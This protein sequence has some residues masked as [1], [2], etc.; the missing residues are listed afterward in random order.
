MRGCFSQ[1]AQIRDFAAPTFRDNSSSTGC[2][3]G[4]WFLTIFDGPVVTEHHAM[5]VQRRQAA[6]WESITTISE[7]AP[8]SA[9]NANGPP[10]KTS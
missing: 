2:P 7:Y 3:S 6:V 4:R 10:R 9:G 5:P 1:I 8:D